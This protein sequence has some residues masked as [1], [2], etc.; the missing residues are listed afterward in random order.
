M[1]ILSFCKIKLVKKLKCVGKGIID[2]ENNLT[3]KLADYLNK[4]NQIFK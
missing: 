1:Y 2:L 4:F 3:K